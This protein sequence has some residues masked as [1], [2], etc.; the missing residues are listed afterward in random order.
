MKQLSDVGLGHEGI[1]ITANHR[2]CEHARQ[3]T[4]KWTIRKYSDPRLRP[5]AKIGMTEL[6]A[7]AFGIEPDEVEVF[8][9]NVMLNEGINEL[10]T[11]LCSAGGTKF[12]NANARL[13]VGDSATGEDATHTGL[14]AASNKAW[15]AMNGG[16]PTYGTSQ[17]AVWQS[18]F[19]E[20]E[21]NF[22]WNEFTVVN[23]ADDTGDN[24][25]RKV[26]GKGTKSGGTWT[27]TLEITLS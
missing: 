9:G 11:I 5:F 1:G 15:K 23:A 6:A 4:K 19:G 21:G 17:K 20:S 7:F 2:V 13:G 12:D 10:W 8:E 22:A 27:L 24:L 25:N 18:D 26:V 14:Q 16:Y 3:L